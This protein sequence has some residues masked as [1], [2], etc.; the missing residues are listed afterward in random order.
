[1]VIV[2]RTTVLWC[3]SKFDGITD[4][5]RAKQ[6]KRA[7]KLDSAGERHNYVRACL[8]VFFRFLLIELSLVHHHLAKSVQR[9]P[10]L[11]SRIRVNVVK[12]TQKRKRKVH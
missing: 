7:H 12:P 5:I 6:G 2:K 4:C 10:A 3:E 8:Y 11:H 9:D 1:M